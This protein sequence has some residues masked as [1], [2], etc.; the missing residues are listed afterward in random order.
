MSEPSLSL[1]AYAETRKRRWTCRV[2]ELTELPEIIAARDN[3][4][5]YPTIVTWLSEVR[6][7]DQ[8]WITRSRLEDHF[9]NGHV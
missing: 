8:G 7:Y 4:V 1:A 6:G 3:G 9:R 5:S 2:C